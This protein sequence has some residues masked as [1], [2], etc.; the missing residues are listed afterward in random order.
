MCSDMSH[1]SSRVFF[2]ARWFVSPY[3]AATAA[4]SKTLSV[5]VLLRSVHS[6]NKPSKFL[7]EEEEIHEDFVL[8]WGPGGQKINKTANCV[9]LRHRSTGI[10]VKCQDTRSLEQNR[11]I[12]RIRLNAKLDEYFNGQQSLPAQERRAHDAK[13]RQRYQR[14]KRRLEAKLEFKAREGLNQ[15]PE[16]VDSE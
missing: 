16:P 14:S 8:G 11:L 4:S 12:A 13:E 6:T 15:K 10:S 3:T 7:F 2:L 5:G 1:T 9:F